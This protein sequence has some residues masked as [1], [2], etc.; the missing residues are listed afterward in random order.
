MSA[1]DDLDDLPPGGGDAALAA[2]YVLR[3]LDDAEARACAAREAA[4]PAFAAEVARWRTELAGLDAAFA[5]VTPPAALRGRVE[6]RLFP[7]PR[8]AT[9]LA[10]L[11]D[12]VGL[13]RGLAAVAT[14]AALWLGVAPLRAPE[15]SL[16]AAMAPREGGGEFVL[17]FVPETGAVTLTRLAGAAEPGRVLQL[18]ALVD[19]APVSLGV[20]PETPQA[21]LTLPP[22]LAARLGDGTLVE[23]TEEPEGGS[24]GPTG[25]ILALG[26]LRDV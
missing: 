24:P 25:T 1:Q 14:A 10:R 23:V 12:S 4:D 16:V 18:W 3:L 21:E 13:W 7:E 9:G 5:P 15:P 22:D 19:Q 6:A 17:N 20:L 11:W 8:R 26:Y 2:E